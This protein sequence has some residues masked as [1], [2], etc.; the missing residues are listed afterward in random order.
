[1]PEH[2]TFDLDA[3]FA[4]LE[5]DI[6]TLSTAPGAGVAVA[7]ARRR[8]RTRAGAI[9]VAAVLA[10]G[11]VAVGQGLSSRDDSVPPADQLPTPAPLDGP[12]L[13]AATAGWTPAWTTPSEQARLKLANSFGGVCTPNIT[14]GRG[15]IVVLGNSHDDVALAVMS[16]Y[17]ADATEEQHSWHRVERQLAACQ[18]AQLVSSFSDPSGA[19]GHTYR[20]AATPSETA[21]EY[22]WIVST[23]QG[24]GV[25]KIFGQ[26]DTL[27]TGNDRSVADSL[28]AAVQDPSSYDQQGTT[29]RSGVHRIDPTKT[30]GQVWAEDFGPA[31]A[32]W[33]NP[34]EP[35]LS[36]ITGSQLPS[37]AGQFDGGAPGPGETVNVGRNGHEW[38]HWFRDETAATTAL[39][40]LQQNLAA[41]STPFTFHSVTLS[42]GRPV[43][44]GVGPEVVW[45]ERVASHVLL[46]HIPAGST[47]PPDDVSLK[48]G[49]VLEHVLEQPA[50]TTMSPGE[51]TKVPAWMQQEI[52]AAPT[53]GP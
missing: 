11:G 8:R 47:P 53:F 1:M 17:G 14:G 33:D 32:G 12:H 50:T 9:A 23:G 39:E 31:L 52:A 7:R 36:G 18:G 22:E 26:S 15:G 5:Q 21:P 35:Q 28:L 40:R 2:E 38:V 51:D 3:A 29:P 41:C 46:V 20:I 19:Q 6:T 4:R 42:D 24:I 27:P 16:D 30:V 45:I 10:V 34:W 37:C 43:L 49:A 25:L 13:T 48:V 44:V